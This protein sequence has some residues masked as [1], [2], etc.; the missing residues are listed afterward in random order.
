MKRIRRQLAGLL[1][2]S[3]LLAIFGNVAVAQNRRGAQ[4][5]D[6]VIVNMADTHSAYDAYPRLVTMAKRLRA[7]YDEASLVFALNGDLFELGNAVA[8]RSAGEAD[9]EFLR[10]LGTLAP[11]VVNM[12]NHEFDFVSPKQ[13]IETARHHDITVLG[14]IRD[15]ESGE[16]LAPEFTDI[17]VGDQRVRIVGVATNQMNTY[18]ASVREALSIPDPTEWSRDSLPRI[19]AAADHTIILSHAGLPADK[20]ILPNAPENV[21]FAVGGHDHLT[22]RQQFHGIPY[23]HNGFRGELVNVTEVYL[24]EDTPTLVY[25]N[26]ETRSVEQPDQR[27]AALIEEMR[28]R[29]L[30]AEDL[31]PVGTVPRDMTVREA[32]LWS[33]KTVRDAMGAD[34]AFLNHTSFGSGLQEGALPK[35]RF[36]QFMRFDNDVMVATVD[37]ETLRTI[38]A[39]SNQH[40]IR[41]LAKRSGDFLYASDLEIQDGREYRIATSS[42]VALD[43]NQERYLGTTVTFDKVEGVTTKGI[44]TDA[45]Q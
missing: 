20:A 27:M 17:M 37:A 5:P 29:H 33:V 12:G 13:F 7:E 4:T 24:E 18:P 26:I 2:G 1:I 38:M 16:L 3:L 28:D 19:A 22:F 30:T 45:M 39:R 23:M 43:F 35:Y 31:A 6:L 42:W 25:R 9:W 15:A 44:L 40:E 8:Q 32:A 36:D 10:R 41:D 34:A 21:L 11:V 14:T